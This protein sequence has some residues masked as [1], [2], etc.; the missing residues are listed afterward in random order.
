MDSNNKLVY[1]FP[2]KWYDKAP[3][4]TINHYPK[5]V[6]DVFFSVVGM[7]RRLEPIPKV[8]EINTPEIPCF[9]AIVTIHHFPQPVVGMKR[10]LELRKF[11]A[12]MQLFQSRVQQINGYFYS[13]TFYKRHL[14]LYDND[15]LVFFP[16]VVSFLL[17]STLSHKQLLANTC[18]FLDSITKVVR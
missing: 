14:L 18:F 11:P 5:Q 3:L 15:K 7:K 12:L 13:H 4:V 1:V 6:L 10:R 9:D 16:S 8:P 17:F 2:H